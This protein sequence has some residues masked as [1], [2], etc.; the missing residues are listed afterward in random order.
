MVILKDC[1]L[2]QHYAEQSGHYFE[3]VAAA[4]FDTCC[5]EKP[6]KK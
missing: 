2:M 1:Q 5:I 3:A 6:L 4:K